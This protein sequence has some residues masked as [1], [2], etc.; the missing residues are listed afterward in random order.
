MHIIH[1]FVPKY[2]VINTR[3]QI[4]MPCTI[5]D[6][7]SSAYK[8]GAICGMLLGVLETANTRMP[9]CMTASLLTVEHMLPACS[10]S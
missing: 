4:Y 7:F 2:H 5:I 6:K 1:I 8:G 3:T 10:Q 9:P